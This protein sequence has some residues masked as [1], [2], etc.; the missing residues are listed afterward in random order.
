MSTTVM[1]MAAKLELWRN[2]APGM[3][4]YIAFDLQGR[5]KTKTVPGG[6]TFTLSTFERQINQERAAT[7]EQDLFRNGTFILAKPSDETDNDEIFSPNALTDQ[8]I[9]TIVHDV[10]F[11]DMKINDVID[12]IDSGVTLFRLY[13]AFTLEEKAPERVK[14]AIKKKRDSLEATVANEREVVR[15]SPEE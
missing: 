15:T 12:Q 1:Q 2:T 3:R 6:R 9:E 13:E 10:V 7:P 8:E 5:E 4:W 11:G 14:A